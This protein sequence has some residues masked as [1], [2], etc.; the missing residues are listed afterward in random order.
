MFNDY[1]VV[2]SVLFLVVPCCCLLFLLLLVSAQL[3]SIM[4][5]GFDGFLCKFS[6]WILVHSFFSLFFSL[7]PTRQPKFVYSFINTFYLMSIRKE[8]GGRKEPEGKGKRITGFTSSR[9]LIEKSKPSLP[10][11]PSTILTYFPF[12]HLALRQ[13]ALA[14]H[15]QHH[16]RRRRRRHCRR[17]RHDH[18]LSISQLKDEV[19]AV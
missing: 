9:P 19:Q 14:Y 4:K 17:H 15:N 10:S 13:R 8:Q 5:I 2:F 3:P 6:H 11:T 16:H 12:R 7:F 18:H 1:D